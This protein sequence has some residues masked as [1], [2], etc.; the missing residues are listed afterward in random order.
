LPETNFHKNRHWKD[1]LCYSCKECTLASNRR[2]WTKYKEQRIKRHKKWE[3]NNKEYR[4]KFVNDKYRKNK[5][6]VIEAYGGRCQKCGY[7][8]KRA[9]CV[10][11]VNG[12]GRKQRKKM[13]PAGILLYIIK[14]NFPPQYQ[15]LCSNC[16][17]IKMYESKEFPG[18]KSH[19]GG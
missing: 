8:D 9:L 4:R 18:Y 17:V 13:S 19:Q 2:S 5:D 10:D 3:E 14:A 11:H 12:N 6:I 1:G 7:S 15:V 16:N